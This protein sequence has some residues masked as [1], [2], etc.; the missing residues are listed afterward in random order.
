VKPSSPQ[1]IS[2]FPGFTILFIV[3]FSLFGTITNL[4]FHEVFSV[5]AFAKQKGLR[6]ALPKEL[7]EWTKQ[8]AS[9]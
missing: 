9:K 1:N 3:F 7:A 6:K 8:I 4:F 5:N 2:H